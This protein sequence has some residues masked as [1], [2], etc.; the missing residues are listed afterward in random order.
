MVTTKQLNQFKNKQKIN[1]LP[2][3]R[4]SATEPVVLGAYLKYQKSIFIISNSS[5][6]NNNH[7][8]FSKQLL[9]VMIFYPSSKVVSR[10]TTVK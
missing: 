7:S 1:K 2:L 10:Q 4:T 9:L 5:K 3:S 8:G 6:N